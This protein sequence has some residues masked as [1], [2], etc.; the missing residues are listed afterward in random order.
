MKDV[1]AGLVQG[2]LDAGQI[3]RKIGQMQGLLLRIRFC[4]F[5]F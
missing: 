5:L 2:W 4:N 1:G 3:R